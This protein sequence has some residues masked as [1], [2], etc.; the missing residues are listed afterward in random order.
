MSS[1]LNRSQML[2]HDFAISG[3]VVQGVEQQVSKGFLPNAGTHPDW[4]PWKSNNSIF[5][6]PFHWNELLIP[7]TFVGINDVSVNLDIPV[8]MSLYFTLQASLYSTGAR[9]FIFYQVPPFDRSPKGTFAPPLPF[10][11]KPL[12]T[13]L[14]ESKT[15]YQQVASLTGTPNCSLLH[16]NSSSPSQAPPS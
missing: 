6:N 13:S 15:E 2:V 16:E 12:L 11:F 10:P 7:V 1:Q 4:A 5:C 14:Q 8:Q 3:H 9:N